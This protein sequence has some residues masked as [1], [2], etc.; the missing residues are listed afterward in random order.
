[1][2]DDAKTQIDIDRGRAG[3][4]S[5]RALG[6]RAG[7]EVDLRPVSENSEEAN[8][9]NLAVAVERL[10]SIVFEQQRSNGKILDQSLKREREKLAEAEECVD[11]YQR[12]VTRR[13]ASIAELEKL[14]SQVPEIEL[15][16]IDEVSE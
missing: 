6:A 12:E 9:S 3:Q 13:K 1:M 10:F 15:P 11:W 7:G 16:S 14:R 5:A 4:A 2:S 8:S